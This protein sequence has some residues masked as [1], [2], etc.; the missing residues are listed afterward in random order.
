V[1]PDAVKVAE[2]PA[3]MIRSLFAMPELS[4]SVIVMVGLAVTVVL[5]VAVQPLPDVA[6]T[7]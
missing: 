3:Q 7:V 5:A 4:V 6:V 1:P 2:A